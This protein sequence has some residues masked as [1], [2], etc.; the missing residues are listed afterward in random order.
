MYIYIYTYIYIDICVYVYVYIYIYIHMYVHIY[1][2]KY[3]VVTTHAYH[4]LF[5]WGSPQTLG[6]H[7]PSFFSIEVVASQRSLLSKNGGNI[8]KFSTAHVG[9]VSQ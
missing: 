4:G 6:G 1:I 7:L 9:D 2:Y 8:T 5:F 3:I